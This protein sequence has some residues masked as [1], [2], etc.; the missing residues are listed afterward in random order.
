MSGILLCG[1]RYPAMRCPVACCT[2]SGSVLGHVRYRQRRPDCYYDSAMRCP[3]DRVMR[4]AV[5]GS[6][7]W[8]YESATGSVVLRSGMVLRV[9]ERAC[10][11]EI[12]YG[13][14]RRLKRAERLFR[15][16]LG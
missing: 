4:C 3:D 15:F 6:R 14:T 5:L 7:L 2:M 13:A 1:V 9:C 10:C 12:G 16:S 11:T 8:C